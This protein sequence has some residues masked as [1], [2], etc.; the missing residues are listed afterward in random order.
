MRKNKGWIIES[1][2][3]AESTRHALNFHLYEEGQLKGKS[4]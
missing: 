4:L 2:I 1:T 3:A